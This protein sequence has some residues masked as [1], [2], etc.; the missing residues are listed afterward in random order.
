MATDTASKLDELLGAVAEYA[1]DSKDKQREVALKLLDNEATKAI[2]EVLLKKGL[3]KRT[4]DATAQTSELEAH[5]TEVKDELAQTRQQIRDLESK[6][7]NWERLREET[8]RKWQKKLDE[9]ETKVT[10]ERRTSLTDKV[11]IERGKFI[12]ALRVG[13]PGGVTKLVGDLIPSHYADR[14]VPDPESRTVKVLEIGEKDSYYDPAEGEPAEQL[15]RDVIAKLEPAARIVGDP[16]PGGGTQSG[17]SAMDKATRQIADQKR[18]DP[19]Y[20]L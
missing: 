19:L 9:A 17:G 4:A 6:Q 14:F 1:G 18:R 8:D 16:E 13:Q 5:L 10:E 12:Q 20:T 3:S 11:G 2:G 7:P 15:A